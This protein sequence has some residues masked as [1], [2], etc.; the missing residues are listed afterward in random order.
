MLL[1]LLII[2]GGTAGLVL[3]NRVSEILDVNVLVLESGKDVSQK[4]EVQ[5]PSR[6]MSLLGEGSAKQF[7]SVPQVS[8]CRHIRSC[9]LEIEIGFVRANTP[10]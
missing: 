2:G 4:P 3:A 6:W 7:N 1:P 8:G 9:S 10:S 5:D